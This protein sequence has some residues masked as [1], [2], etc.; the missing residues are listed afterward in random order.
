MILAVLFSCQRCLPAG[1]KQKKASTVTAAETTAAA[2]IET[3]SAEYTCA[4]PEIDWKCSIQY[5]YRR[6]AMA[7]LL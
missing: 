1:L 6:R 7:K 2:E 3:T 4:L 5:S